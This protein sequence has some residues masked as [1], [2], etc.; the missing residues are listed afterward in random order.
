VQQGT[1]IILMALYR[2][3]VCSDHFMTV[4]RAM[5]RAAGSATPAPGDPSSFFTCCIVFTIN[6]IPISTDN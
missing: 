2:N 3:W 6:F 5:R 1:R 4:I